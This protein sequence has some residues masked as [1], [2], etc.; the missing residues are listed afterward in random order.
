[1]LDWIR[2]KFFCWKLNP[3]TPSIV[4]AKDIQTFVDGPKYKKAIFR[5]PMGFILIRFDL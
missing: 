1:M 5:E 3:I 4:T 2:N